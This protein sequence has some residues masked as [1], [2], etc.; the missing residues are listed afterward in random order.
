MQAT[1]QLL[2]TCFGI[3]DGKFV[4]TAPIPPP[5]N[6]APWMEDRPVQAFNN[7]TRSAGSQSSQMPLMPGSSTRT[8][9]QQ[10]YSQSHEEKILQALEILFSSPV[11]AYESAAGQLL[12]MAE[13]CPDPTEQAKVQLL[14]VLYHLRSQD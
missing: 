12:A 4:Q 14:E 13:W 8:P 6:S 2:E 5:S 9:T 3:I 7:V 11:P 1:V 10:T